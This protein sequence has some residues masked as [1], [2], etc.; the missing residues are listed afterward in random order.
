MQ[1]PIVHVNASTA[2]SQI[3]LFSKSKLVP[4]LQ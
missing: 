3:I 4:V 1:S 2:V